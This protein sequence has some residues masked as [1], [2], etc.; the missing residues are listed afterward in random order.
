MAQTCFED[1]ASR[2]ALSFK[3]KGQRKREATIEDTEQ[4]RGR[5]D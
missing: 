4:A 5:Q 1:D 3:V 2:K